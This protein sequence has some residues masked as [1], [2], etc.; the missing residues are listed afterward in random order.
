MNVICD[1]RV[2][3]SACGQT[4]PLAIKKVRSGSEEQVTPDEGP[5]L[6]ELLPPHPMS[7]VAMA[8]AAAAA[9]SRILVT[10]RF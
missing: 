7:I 8:A 3:V 2:T 9:A 6:L 10:G 4:A 1:P 5:V